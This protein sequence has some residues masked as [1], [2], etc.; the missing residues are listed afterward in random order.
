MLNINS[1]VL[2]S[3]AL[4]MSLWKHECFRV[5]A[6]RFTTQTDKDWF[7]KSIIQ[8]IEA[9]ICFQFGAS[10]ITSLEIYQIH[11]ISPTLNEQ[12]VAWLK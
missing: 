10:A 7:E 3:S 9:S 11:F 4:L 12:I 5:V 2:S 1:E 6:D 8:V